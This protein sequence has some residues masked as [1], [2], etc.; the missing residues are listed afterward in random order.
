MATK[1]IAISEEAYQRLKA[2]K[3]PGES[4][5]AL[6]NRVTQ[7]RGILELVGVLTKTEGDQLNQI[8]LIESY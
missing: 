4:F 2:L 1:I 5:T 6:I 7:S 3:K 8:T